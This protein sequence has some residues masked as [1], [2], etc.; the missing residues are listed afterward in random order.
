[1][2]DNDGVEGREKSWR[3]SIG[4]CGIIKFRRWS[5]SKK[6]QVNGKDHA[7]GRLVLRIMVSLYY[8]METQDL[9]I[10]DQIKSFMTY[11]YTKYCT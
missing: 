10:A 6:G 11:I 7:L 3:G 2:I 5:K 8:N 1:M 4:G 9:V